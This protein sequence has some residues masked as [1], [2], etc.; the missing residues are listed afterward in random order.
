MHAAQ[1]H[2]MHRVGGCSGRPRKP[3]SIVEWL[4]SKLALSTLF[5]SAYATAWPDRSKIFE[6][7]PL[8]RRALHRA[9]LPSLLQLLEKALPAFGEISDFAN[10]P[11]VMWESG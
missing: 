8:Y 11:K 10:R 5:F 1:A 3:C 6:S 2:V 9:E 4:L 7:H